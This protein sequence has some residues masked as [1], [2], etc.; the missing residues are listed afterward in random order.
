MWTRTFGGS[1]LTWGVPGDD[2]TSRE[3]CTRR[4]SKGPDGEG[5]GDPRVSVTLEPEFESDSIDTLKPT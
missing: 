2:P 4:K 1:A 5:H 3:D